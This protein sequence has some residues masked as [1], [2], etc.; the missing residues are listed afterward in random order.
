MKGA[1]NPVTHIY[2]PEDVQRIIEYGRF[3]GVRIVP[4]FDTPVSDFVFNHI[5]F[6]IWAVGSLD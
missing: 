4:E 2:T 3:R 1:Y 6:F 5:Y